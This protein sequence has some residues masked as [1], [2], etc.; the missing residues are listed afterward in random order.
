MNQNLI[1]LCV[2]LL[3]VPA[4]QKIGKGLI[5]IA[6]GR[7]D[8]YL[9]HLLTSVLAMFLLLENTAAIWT[10]R[11]AEFDYGILSVIAV[12]L[13]LSV[14]SLFLFPRDKSIDIYSHYY[15]NYKRIFTLAAIAMFINFVSHWD[16]ISNLFRGLAIILCIIQITTSNENIHKTIT[17]T[18][19]GIF[20]AYVPIV[21][22]LFILKN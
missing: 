17:L 20:V 2:A 19:L 22:V 12:Y 7:L 11:N 16:F 18:L 6:F 13:C 5:D 3:A 4:I 10:W 1:Q 21:W 15:N 14:I 9:P 8:T